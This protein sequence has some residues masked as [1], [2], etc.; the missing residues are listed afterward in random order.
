MPNIDCS[1]KSQ[2]DPADPDP[3]VIHDGEKDAD[4]QYLGRKDL[5]GI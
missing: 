2:V 4:S 5:G 3:Q 1:Q